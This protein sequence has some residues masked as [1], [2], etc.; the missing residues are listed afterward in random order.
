MSMA[1]SPLVMAKFLGQV[2]GKTGYDGV[3]LVGRA[4]SG[5]MDL[6]CVLLVFLIG[7]RLYDA[8]VGLL[9][10]LLLA[11]DRAQH[12]AV[13]LFHR[14]HLHHALCDPGALHGR[15]R[16]AGRGLGQHPAAG[17]AF[18]LA[19]SAKISVLTFLLVIGLAY[20]AAHLARCRSAETAEPRPATTWRARWGGWSVAS[21][22]AS[23]PSGEQAA[24]ARS[25]RLLLAL[26]RAGL[27]LAGVLLVAVSSFA[28][29]NRR[30]SRGPGFFGLKLNPSGARTWTISASW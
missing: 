23:R 7:R 15:A 16:G 12:P 21:A 28:W 2:M 19:V 9:G 13:A 26:V 17:V 10:A 4:M 8:R 6:L 22:C 18:G 1:C 30:P 20:A 29:R 14:G 3:Y 25:D 11:A 27:V 5:V 24:Y